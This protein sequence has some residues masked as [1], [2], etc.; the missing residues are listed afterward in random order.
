MPWYTD[1]YNIKGIDDCNTIN[2][3]MNTLRFFHDDY[4]KNIKDLSNNPAMEVYNLYEK[5][6]KTT[7]NRSNSFG[8]KT[9][10]TMENL[11][12]LA[13]IEAPFFTG[14]NENNKYIIAVD[15]TL[16]DIYSTIKRMC[17]NNH[18]PYYWVKVFN[19]FIRQIRTSC[20]KYF[21]ST[22]RDKNGNLVSHHS[23]EAKWH[24]T[25]WYN[26]TLS[27]DIT[28]FS[29]VVFNRIPV[30]RDEDNELVLYHNNLKEYITCAWW[31]FVFA[32]IK[33]DKILLNTLTKVMEDIDVCR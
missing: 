30:K 5:F 15:K 6:I 31:N 27:L 17:Y 2:F 3:H 13:G 29:T 16:V 10:Y 12:T 8:V 22:K 9:T 33:K 4:V 20:N 1:E 23:K 19:K 21:F 28:R 26:H 7:V 11:I 32:N 14:I 18:T 24:F 25:W